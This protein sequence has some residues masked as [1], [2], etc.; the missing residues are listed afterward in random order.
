MSEAAEA[1][2]PVFP[3]LESGQAYLSSLMLANPLAAEQQLT[4]F[5]DSLLA[6]PPDPGILLQL[7]EQ[8]RTPLCFVEEEMARRYQN[9]PVPL[10]QE[11]NS[12]F[13]QVIAAWRKMGKAYALCARMEEP[14]TENPDYEALVATI[15]HRCIYYTGRVILEHYPARRELPAGIWLELHGYYESAEEWGVASLPVSDMLENDLQATHCMAA[16]V[17]LLLIDMA[18]PYGQNARNLNL[19]RRWASMWAPL[20]S[21]EH[22]DD[23]LVIPSYIVELM[24]DQ[25]LHPGSVIE[26]PSRDVRQL[27]TTRLGLQISHVLSQLKMRLTPSQLGLGEDTAG[28]VTQ[29]LEYLLRPW[30]QSASLRRFRRF[31]SNGTARVGLDFEDMHFFVSGKPFEQP[32]A[33]AAYSRDEFDQ[34]FTFRDSVEPS[35]HA[36]SIRPPAEFEAEAWAVVNHSASGFCMSRPVEGERLMLGQLLSV[37]PHDGER[38]LLAH[39]VWL[40]A[41]DSGSLLLGLS[42]LPGVPTPIAVRIAALDGHAAN[43]R[44]VQA[45][46]MPALPAVGEEASLVLPQGFY[47]AS[48]ELE[49]FSGDTL[50]K[51]RMRHMLHRGHDFERVSF[52]EV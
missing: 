5:L 41:E 30:T 6:E 45:F 7:L 22:L 23:E 50:R 33:A 14:A 48:R 24:K 38:F 26:G 36:L 4:L 2:M 10:N 19:I 17:S 18:N 35:G 15:L 47:Q 12:A 31:A 32:G 52:A 27:D 16:Y 46:M 44:Y 13:L 37:C 25:A 40:M 3:D 11:E 20:V 42:T 8:A 29:L 28:H 21:V 39:I 49:V 51:L 43:D 34:L 1:Q 9:K